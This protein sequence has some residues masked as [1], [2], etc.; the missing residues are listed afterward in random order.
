MTIYHNEITK[1][2]EKQNIM[3][4]DMSDVY[5]KSYD[6]DKVNLSINVK[7]DFK[8]IL[9]N[10]G[11]AEC[12]KYGKLVFEIFK[13]NLKLVANKKQ[14]TDFNANNRLNNLDVDFENNFVKHSIP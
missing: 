12:R 1:N 10:F 8:N 11:I 7:L 6:N 13:P 5:V 14:A 4:S 3:S 9:E 2:T